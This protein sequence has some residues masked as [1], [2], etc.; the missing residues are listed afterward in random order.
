MAGLVSC[1][2]R[3]PVESRCPHARQT[4]EIAADYKFDNGLWVHDFRDAFT[5]SMLQQGYVEPF[6]CLDEWTCLLTRTGNL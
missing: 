3:F 2:F 1:E 5:C 6:D 4:F